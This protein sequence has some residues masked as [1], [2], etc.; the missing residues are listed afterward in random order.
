M[1]NKLTFTQRAKASIER[2]EE[3]QT[4]ERR[5]TQLH[6]AEAQ[7]QYALRYEGTTI[8]KKL[9]INDLYLRFN[10]LVGVA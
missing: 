7:L 2:A 8:N 1:K 5:F 3:A 9:D 6:I 4:S 10:T